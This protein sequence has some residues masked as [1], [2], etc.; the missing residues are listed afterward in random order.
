VFDV[1]IVNVPKMEGH[2]LPAAPAIL[3]GC[4]QYLGLRARTIDLN[5]QFLQACEDR[6]IDYRVDLVGITEDYLPND[7]L[8][9]LTDKLLISW[10]DQ[11]LVLRPKVVA[12]SVFTYYSQYFAK[13][14]AQE[15]R[16]WD[17]ECK[18]VM[19]G[20]GL[21]YS[22]NSDAVFGDN[23]KQQG[24]LDHYIID[25][26]EK[27]WHDYLIELFKLGH[28]SF[29]DFTNLDLPFLPD[30]QDY[31]IEDYQKFAETTKNK[32]TVPITGS[33][34]CVR[35]CD[36]CEI[37]QHWRFKQRS[38][39]HIVDE[40]EH[41]LSMVNDPHIHFT[42]SLVNGSLKEFDAM[43]DHLAELRK[44]RAFT[45]GGQFII[46]SPEQFGEVRWQ[47]MADSGARNLEIGIETGSEKLRFLMNKPFTNHDLD[48]SMDM[49]S[50]YKITSVFLIMIGHPLESL[51]DFNATIDM[52]ER[53]QQY[54]PVISSVQLGYAVAI[55]SGTPLF[56]DKD[57]I[58]LTTTK[59]PIIWM[60]SKNPDLTFDER[61]R[62]RSLA[63]EQVLNL[64]YKLSS[65]NHTS[66]KEMQHNKEKFQKNISTLE[67]ISQRV[68]E[69]SHV[70]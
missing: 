22:L 5:L 9:D 48:F 30:Y 43:L 42:D 56:D 55:Q 18:I 34:G 41:I 49:M 37:H 44:N 28:K 20:A 47:R 69:K 67:A 70:V 40:V 46:R 38:A 6:D 13:K 24:L 51:E 16:R 27:S 39:K 19:G 52:L 32:I 29:P 61:L 12:V 54:Q 66:I 15:I 17:K 59:N 65:D 33:R 21:K 63:A 35:K 2:Y 36:F 45:W 58:G 11:I 3:K 1:V 4:C 23:L 26:G 7:Q 14:L 60:C 57:K 62:R 64:G 68:F 25:D 53:Y 8:S 50:R 10:I 31:V